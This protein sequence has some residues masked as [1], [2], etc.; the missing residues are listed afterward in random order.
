VSE[1][2][3]QSIVE[4][5]A[6]SK[7][8]IEA[9]ARRRYQSSES[10]Q[11][12]LISKYR[13]LH[14]YY[15]PLNQDQWPKD[16]VERPGKIHV[17]ANLCKTACDVDA[18]VQSLL[19]RFTIPMAN[20]PADDRKRAEGTEQLM[21]EWLDLSGV[22]EW[23]HILCQVRSIYGKGVLKPFWDDDLR[24]GDV[25]VIENPANL[26]IGWGSSD[27]HAIDWTV[28][29][30]GL[31]PQEAMHRWPDLRI[32]PG[33][34]LDSPPRVRTE[35]SSHTDPLNQ[36]TDEFWSPMYREYSEYERK[37]VRVW[38]YWYKDEDGTPM[39]AIMV[40]G[41][42]CEGPTAHSELA[43]I[44][45]IPIENDHEP[46][47]PEGI[48]TMEPIL[49]TQQEFN[50]L[51]SHGLQH[52]ADE[53]DPAWYISGPSAD[54][55]EAGIVPKAGHVIGVGE[56]TPGAWPKTANTFPIESMLSE[57]WNDFH[58]LTGLP[59]VM[60]GQTPGADTSGRAIAVQVEAAANRLDPRRR[61]LYAG[62]KQLLIFWVK[63][64][65]KKNPVITV[66]EAD[67]ENG[68]EEKTASVGD[69]VK[70]FY[71]WKIIAPELTPRD[72]FEVTQN[73]INKVN[74]K[75]TSFRSAMDAIGVEAPENELSIIT[76][77]QSNLKLN[78]AAVQ[79][80]VSVYTIMQQV[81]QMAMQNQQMAMEM[82]QMMSQ[83]QG[84]Q[85]GGAPGTPQSAL[86][87]A[88]GA[89]NNMM[90]AQ[91]GAQPA[92]LGEDQN[93]EGGPGMPMTQPG[94]APPAGAG[95]E[96]AGTMTS[97]SRQDGDA[98]N[99]IAFNTDFGG[100]Q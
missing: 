10:Y 88:Q 69:L 1:E 66:Q 13:I 31:S 92:P 8:A 12:N 45:Y 35:E 9:A 57:L 29:E 97:L 64:A 84:Q 76:E 14:H 17:T 25:S 78:P 82:K 74:A 100:G 51:L 18:R 32:E 43:D 27:Y 3:I 93:M 42:I 72:N 26:R 89:T 16:K 40:N 95:A 90:Q 30:Y 94:M 55:V 36:N 49:D 22:D 77:E 68:I 15:N 20:I 19:P 56:N 37:Q 70:G 79:S 73:E 41:V 99:Q 96:G 54:T 87:Q 52:V 98:L 58:R 7:P 21:K 59:E 2:A 24:R 47:S 11:A 5:F 48:S 46:G 85:P 23:L 63:M 50:R 61:R 62:L 33:P 39:N 38:D 91:Q 44:P 60:F 83:M 53:V 75:L 67:E 86:A 71:Q 4:S 28:Y 65:E 80:Q 6:K 34:S 81:Q